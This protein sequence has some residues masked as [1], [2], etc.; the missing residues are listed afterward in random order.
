ML[1]VNTLS[2]SS[3]CPQLQSE[4]LFLFP[5][6][7]C[8]WVSS[9][10]SP[11]DNFPYLLMTNRKWLVQL[12]L[13]CFLFPVAFEQHFL[14]PG[15]DSLECRLSSLWNIDTSVTKKMWEH[16]VLLLNCRRGWLCEK[17][18]EQRQQRKWEKKGVRWELSMKPL[19]QMFI[20]YGFQT[21]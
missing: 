14:S 16:F 5:F 20:S 10:T 17:K 13:G 21:F 4:F 15:C 19:K 8:I 6:P 2:S 9:L 3:L 7:F 12:I 18:E 1:L 11:S